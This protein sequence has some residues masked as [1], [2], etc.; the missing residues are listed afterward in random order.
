[1]LFVYY[2]QLLD[3]TGI[4][5]SACWLLLE[6][7]LVRLKSSLPAL[8]LLL[9]RRKTLTVFSNNSSASEELLLILLSMP[10]LLVFTQN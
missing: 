7:A 4:P 3:T 9:I 8:G 1:M 2:K 5:A 10:T 6:N